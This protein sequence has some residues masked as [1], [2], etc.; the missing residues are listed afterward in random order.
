MDGPTIKK[1]Q[2]S[3]ITYW[4]KFNCSHTSPR[5]GLHFLLDLSTLFFLANWSIY[6]YVPTKLDSLLF[7]Q[8][9]YSFIP[10]YL[11]VSIPF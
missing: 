7:L 5:F 2:L 9:P 3:P 8:G 10:T 4:K 6:T 11:Y 1:L